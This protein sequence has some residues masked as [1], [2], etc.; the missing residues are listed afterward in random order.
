M[1][2]KLLWGS[3]FLGLLLLMVSTSVALAAPS[4]QTVEP[5][6]QP[7]ASLTPSPSPTLPRWPAP[8]STM[9][10]TSVGGDIPI[11]LVPSNTPL[12]TLALLPPPVGGG[13]VGVDV[14]Y[15]RDGPSF[16][17]PILGSLLYNNTVSPLGR[18]TAGDWIAVQWEGQIGWVWAS[19]VVWDPAL[20]LETLAVLPDTAT[21]SPGGTAAPTALAPTL[22]PTPAR[23]PTLTV[24]PSSTPLPAATSTLQPTVAPLPQPTIP[25]ALPAPNPL[26]GIEGPVKT[27]LLVGGGLVLLGLIVYLWR[28]SAGVREVR[29]YAKGFLF[30][31]CPACH[32]GHLHL[33]Q[34]VQHSMG[35][36]NVRRSVRCDTCRSVLREIR[37]GRWR[38]TVDP[39]VN[40][41]MASRY[42]TRWLSRTDLELLAR[43]AGAAGRS[44]PVGAEASRV[45][46]EELPE[47]GESLFAEEEAAGDPIEE[48]SEEPLLP[49]DASDE[50][51]E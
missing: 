39:Y 33:D 13:R 14:L 50:T 24:S 44:R 9:R 32:E 22:S 10:P 1:D 6:S 19:L 12:P 47:L 30:D 23:T 21:L 37:P 7:T 8:T 46:Q 27:G 31:T 34:L 45:A 5:P 48:V 2:R 20:R 26:E 40:P 25:P 4:Q 38:Y 29:R 16:A 3:W 41:D 42:D 36:P 17:S 35:I 51:I 49:L 43:S 18:N 15:V 11:P 28:R